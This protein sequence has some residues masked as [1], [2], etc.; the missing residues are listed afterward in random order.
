MRAA[1]YERNGSA[2]DVLYVGEVETPQPARNEV[3][4]R[5]HTS[6]VNPS[7]V[8][9]RAGLTRKIAFPRV[10]PHSDGAG[11]IE[12]VG[13]GVPACRIGERVWVW[14][15]QW[16]R[17]F[18]TA[19]QF[20]VLPAEQV[21]PL[22]ANT[23]MD[24]GACLGIPAYTAYHAVVLAGVK[25]GSTVLVAGGAG[26]VGHY[27]VQFAKRRKA[28]VITT[29]SS[30]EK[31]AIAR[32]AGADH[33][34]DY[35]RENVGARVKAITANRGVEAA[36][37]LDLAANAKLLPDVL[38]PKAVVAIYGSSAPELM[39]PFQFLLQNSIELRF[40][41]VYELGKDER[42]CAT[43]DITRARPARTQCGANVCTRRYRGRARSR[44][45]RKSHGECCGQDDVA[46]MSVNDM[47]VPGFRGACHRAAL[48]ADPL[49]HTGYGFLRSRPD[50]FRAGHP[51]TTRDGR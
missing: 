35:R 38:A 22:P 17:P 27:A 34:I 23:G 7:D 6:G 50:R 12:A 3:R 5:L 13:E 41:L 15:G 43:R 29:V 20:V 25:E 21:V 37:E 33:V 48:C 45:M 19:A 8:K 47:R 1:Y 11:E 44:G 9:N 49:A 24:A 39:I 18:G 46:R 26:A 36:I 28:T 16:R 32:H 4:V 40:F 30:P 42:E 2:R 31:T 51:E 10:I 14:N